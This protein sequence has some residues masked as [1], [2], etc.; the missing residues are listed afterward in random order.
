MKKICC[1]FLII[2]LFSIISCNAVINGHRCLVF[3]S[4]Y[5]ENDNYII[6]PE[7]L[8][9]SD[10]WYF[11]YTTDKYVLRIDKEYSY[12]YALISL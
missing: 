5:A 10:D 12:K 11:F 8:S 6:F 4:V 3:D 1:L 7:V 2:F 9:K